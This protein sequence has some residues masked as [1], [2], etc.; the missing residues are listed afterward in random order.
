MNCND[1]NCSQEH[2]GSLER[3]LLESNYL[4]ELQKFTGLPKQKLVAELEIRKKFLDKLVEQNIRE[5][6]K[7]SEMEKDFLGKRK[8]FGEL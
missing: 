8:T 3:T 6:T 1:F 7:V 5:I 2:L 4:K